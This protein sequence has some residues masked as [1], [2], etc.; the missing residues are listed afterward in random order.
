MS[1]STGESVDKR[2]RTC[3]AEEL[4]SKSFGMEILQTVSA[5]YQ[6]SPEFLGSSS[7]EEGDLDMDHVNTTR[8][9]IRSLV[10]DVKTL[11]EKLFATQVDDERRA[12]EDDITGKILL[13]YW[14]GICSEIEQI[15]EKVIRRIVNDGSIS[16]SEQEERSKNLQQ[17]GMIL[18][19][20]TAAASDDD[21]SHLRRILADAEAGI[22]KYELLRGS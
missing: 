6:R 1:I 9:N 12:L 14:K 2:I 4:G 7:G 22:S 17:D 18:E 15:V 10:Q 11:E 21:Q 19:K 20:A 8:D 13:A 3:E 5:V 16:R